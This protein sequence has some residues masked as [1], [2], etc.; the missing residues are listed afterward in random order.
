[1][2]TPPNILFVTLDTFS[3]MGGIQWYNRL[4]GKALIL[5]SAGERYTVSQVS[6][7]DHLPDEE[8]F[9]GSQFKGYKGSKVYFTAGIAPK[10]KSADILVVGHI[11][12]APVAAWYKRLFA[13]RKVVL[14]THGIEVWESLGSSGQQTIQRADK[15]LTVSD[16][17]REKLVSAQ[18]ANPDI[19]EVL[20]NSLDPV[21]MEM[22]DPNAV[23]EWK[24]KHGAGD[25]RIL[26][27]VA[28]YAKSEEQKGYDKVLKLLP[29]LAERIPGFQYILA[30]PA[31]TD[32]ETRIR[33]EY[34]PH[35]EAKTLIL[36]GT[37]SMEDLKYC[38]HAA[39]VFIL[40]SAKEGFGR[41]LVEAAWSG[42]RVVALNAGGS[43]EALLHGQLGELLPDDHEDT[44]L[45]AIEKAFQQPLT[46]GQK[47]KNRKLIDEHFGFD[48]FVRHQN[49]ILKELL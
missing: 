7:Y 13:Q 21:F 46:Q 33:N 11:N 20:S 43:P 44:L 16:Y 42:N 34:A 5:N 45:N 19:I 48:R 23:Q 30:G 25:K 39:E 26:L 47:E 27:T 31:E 18:G 3:R 37:L 2:Q 1:M 15:I 35:I 41:V 9:P 8:Y 14:L 36:A 12:L 49:G 6:L 4:F 28:R 22:P 40:P 32:E 29:Q 38:Y 10:L 24:E 17:T